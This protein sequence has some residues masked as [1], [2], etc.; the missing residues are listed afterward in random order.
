MGALSAVEAVGGGVGARR[1]R[2]RGWVRD[3]RRFAGG[4]GVEAVDGVEEEGGGGGEEDVAIGRGASLLAGVCG[5]REL[6]F[7]LDVF[8]RA[9][10]SEMGILGLPVV[11]IESDG[12]HCCGVFCFFS[13]VFRVA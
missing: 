8:A 6:E 13:F 11:R 5:F 9:E 1:G 10:G 4:A 2:V 7:E 3:T 12:C